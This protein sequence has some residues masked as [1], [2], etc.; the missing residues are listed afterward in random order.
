ME[1]GKLIILYAHIN[2]CDVILFVLAQNQLS[3]N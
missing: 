3:I 1:N 2:G